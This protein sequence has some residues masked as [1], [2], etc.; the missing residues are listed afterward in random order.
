MVSRSSVV[1]I[2]RPESYWFQ[3]CGT[4]ATIAKGQDRCVRLPESW[5]F[6][7][8]AHLAALCGP[9]SNPT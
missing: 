5:S 6:F 3:E 2:M 9:A 1:R 4:V 8:V 7:H